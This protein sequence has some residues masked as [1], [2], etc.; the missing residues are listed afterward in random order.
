MNLEGKDPLALVSL[1]RSPSVV[2][3]RASQDL[4]KK[5]EVEL[6]HMGH[7]LAADTARRDKFTVEELVMPL[8]PENVA[9]VML[10]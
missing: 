9:E 7:T 2:Q 1:T 4:I 6:F 5:R 3:V 10:L 8:V